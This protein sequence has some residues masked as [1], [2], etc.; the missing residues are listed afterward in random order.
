[1]ITNFILAPILAHMV[2]AILLLFFWQRVKAQKII[3][4]IGNLVAFLLCVRLFYATQQHG[5]LIVQAGNWEAPFGIIFVSDTFSSIM[6]LL[7]A[8]VSLAVGIYST[9]ALN[10]SRI[11]YGYFFIFHFLLMGLLGAFL[12]GDI[13]NL[14]VWFEVVI[15]SSFALLAV[16]GKKMRMEAAIKYVTMSILATMIFLTASAIRYGRTG[17]MNMGHMAVKIEAVGKKR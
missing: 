7:T 16:G 8:I 6:V 17:P 4:I 2:T 11:M 12:T 14:Y 9:A 13:F 5:Y 3:S 10:L 15:I 1:M